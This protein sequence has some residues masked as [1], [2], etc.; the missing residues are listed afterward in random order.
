MPYNHNFDGPDSTNHGT[1]ADFSQRVFRDFVENI[2]TQSPLGSVKEH[3]D[4]VAQQMESMRSA[5]LQFDRL[6]LSDDE[7]VAKIEEFWEV[8]NGA[9]GAT[10]R[11]LRDQ[12]FACEQSR[13]AQIFR[14]VKEEKLQHG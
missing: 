3:Q 9:S 2:L 11:Y 14:K 5:K 1:K 7:V 4:M 10:L 6:K 12:G 8:C 13:F